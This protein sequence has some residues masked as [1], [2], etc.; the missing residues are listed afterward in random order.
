MLFRDGCFGFITELQQLGLSERSSPEVQP[1]N[2]AWQSTTGVRRTRWRVHFSTSTAANA[3]AAMTL[4]SCRRGP[5]WV[6][7]GKHR[8]SSSSLHHLPNNRMGGVCESKHGQS[9]QLTR[10]STTM[11]VSS[12]ETS[13]KRHQP[14]STLVP[15]DTSAETCELTLYNAFSNS[16]TGSALMWLGSRTIKGS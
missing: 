13:R 5:Q 3:S 16:V 8:R 7:F 1:R 12:R 11:V 6:G 2:V 10:S 4:P 15:K 14:S 9:F